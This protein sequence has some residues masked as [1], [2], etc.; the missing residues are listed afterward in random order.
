[1]NHEISVRN[2]PELYVTLYQV[3]PRDY[4]EG[5]GLPFSNQQ[6]HKLQKHESSLTDDEYD[7]RRGKM[8]VAGRKIASRVSTT[9]RLARWST[10][11]HRRR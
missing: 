8:K 9:Q 6:Q 2:F 1:L 10:V 11:V 4:Y 3:Q 5:S 7:Y